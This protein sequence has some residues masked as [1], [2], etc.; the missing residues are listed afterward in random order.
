M[1]KVPATNHEIRL[2]RT[3]AR[4]EAKALPVVTRI[5]IYII[6]IAQYAKLNVIHISDPERARWIIVG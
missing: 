1:H 4:R 3:S 2:A 6:S 5:D